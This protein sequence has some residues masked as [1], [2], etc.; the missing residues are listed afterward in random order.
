MDRWV[1]RRSVELTPYLLCLFLPLPPYH[2]ST[3]PS[4]RLNSFP[5]SGPPLYTQAFSLTGSIK[6]A[7]PGQVKK[8][9]L[10]ALLVQDGEGQTSPAQPGLHTPPSLAPPALPPNPIR[11][12]P[13]DGPR[14]RSPWSN[15]LDATTRH[16]GGSYGMDGSVAGWW[17]RV[18]LDGR[19][20]VK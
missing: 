10:A 11:K 8:A 6:R 14:G 19:M 18:R 20:D 12:R 13:T 3:L 5:F 16:S 15:H 1:E 17:G 4:V 9:S 2:I 7:S